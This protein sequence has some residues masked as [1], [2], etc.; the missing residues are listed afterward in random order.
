[1]PF[2]L[3][4]FVGGLTVWLIFQLAYDLGIIQYVGRR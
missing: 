1:M 4:A 3:G 2:L